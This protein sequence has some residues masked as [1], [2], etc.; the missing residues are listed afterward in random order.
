MIFSGLSPRL[1]LKAEFEHVKENGA[2]TM[3][4][5][6]MAGVTLSSYVHVRVDFHNSLFKTVSSYTWNTKGPRDLGSTVSRT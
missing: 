2:T 3:F 6:C 4:C 1:L 5:T